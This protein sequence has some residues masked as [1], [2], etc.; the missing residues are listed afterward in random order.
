M[1]FLF[2]KKV[3]PVK[4]HLQI[5]PVTPAVLLHFLNSITQKNSLRLYLSGASPIAITPMHIRFV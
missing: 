5:Y 3:K 1:R 4:V 2:L